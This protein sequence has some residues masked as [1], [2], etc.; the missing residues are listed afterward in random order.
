M[1]AWL[2]R[3][4]GNVWSPSQLCK[5]KERNNEATHTQL[6]VPIRILLSYSATDPYY[7]ITDFMWS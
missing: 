2:S 7:V 3:M 6:L 4:C 5:M 1:L